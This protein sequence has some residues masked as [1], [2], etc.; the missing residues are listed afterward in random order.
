MC[1]ELSGT[2]RYGNFYFCIELVLGVL[3]GK[4]QKEPLL[5]FWRFIWV[6]YE[7][8]LKTCGPLCSGQYQELE[9]SVELF[10]LKYWWFWK[11]IHNAVWSNFYFLDSWILFTQL[12]T[13]KDCVIKSFNLVNCAYFKWKFIKSLKKKKRDLKTQINKSPILLVSIPNSELGLS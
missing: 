10:L 4:V 5:F 13:F 11:N 3:K 2:L 9:S 8:P 12:V 1:H 6:I 7:Q